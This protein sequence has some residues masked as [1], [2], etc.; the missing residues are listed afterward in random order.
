MRRSTSTDTREPKDALVAKESSS[1]LDYWN[2]LLDFHQNAQG[3]SPNGAEGLDAIRRIHVLL[4]PTWN[5]S[6]VPGHYLKHH[7][8]AAH[9][10]AND[11][12]IQFARKLEIL[13]TIPG[14][15][16]IF[17]RLESRASYWGA[18][19]ELDFALK[20]SLGGFQCRFIPTT[21]KDPTPDLH[22]TRGEVDLVVE[23]T[24]MDPRPSQGLAFAAMHAMQW[25]AFQKKCTAR[26]HISRIPSVKDIDQ[27]ER[28]VTGACEEANKTQGLV[29]V[30]LPE[31]MTCFI[32]PWDH[33]SE[34][35][36][37]WRHMITAKGSR[38]LSMV[39]RLSKL[40]SK[41]SK[42]QLTNARTG[43][44]VIYDQLH[45]MD[46]HGPM[47]REAESEETGAIGDLL[48]TF[49]QVLGTVLIRPFASVR[50]RNTNNEEYGDTYILERSLPGSEGER[51]AVWRNP[52][53]PE[54]CTFDLIMDCLRDYPPNL[55]ASLKG[56]HS[57]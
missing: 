8:W 48:A 53:S 49:S 44:V 37:E 12:L 30:D 15:Q 26:G 9:Q 5:C 18:W 6:Y 28:T 34:I 43:L 31:L 56:N 51:L 23:I 39:E 33:E 50:D 25:S 46:A 13:A 4:G 10:L 42:H 27:I 32:A 47:E 54:D 45:F 57:G 55:R 20:L 14:S 16:A 2:A 29:R 7:L 21:R 17:H 11:W 3:N 38:K 36:E 52:V 41:K 35:P 1:T 19:S 24:T 22:A 40:V